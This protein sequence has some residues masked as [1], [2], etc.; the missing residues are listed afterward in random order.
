MT[1]IRA[2]IAE[3]LTK[4]KIS[5]MSSLFPKMMIETHGEYEYEELYSD[6]YV[7]IKH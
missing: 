4:K 2:K 6:I 3:I 5:P 7:I 1:D